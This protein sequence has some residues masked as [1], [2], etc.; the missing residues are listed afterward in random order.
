MRV[1]VVG[2]VEEYDH[3]NAAEV[4]SKEKLGV[5]APLR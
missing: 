2:A 1:V 4:G 5:V 3:A